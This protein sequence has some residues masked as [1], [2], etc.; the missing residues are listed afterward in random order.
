[1][2]NCSCHEILDFLHTS[3]VEEIPE[4]LSTLGLDGSELDAIL[5]I[6]IAQ[7]D[8]KITDLDEQKGE[9]IEEVNATI[10][11]LKKEL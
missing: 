6:F 8:E 5:I 3:E 7:L 4:Y 2:N 10:A 9:F 1:M 11:E